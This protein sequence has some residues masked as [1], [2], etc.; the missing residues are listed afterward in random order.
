MRV[1][2]RPRP[3]G[4]RDARA[5]AVLR[6]SWPLP[7]I[8]VRAVLAPMARPLHDALEETLGFIQRALDRIVAGE[9]VEA[10]LHNVR[11]YLVNI[12][13]LVERDPGIEAASDDLYAVAKELARGVDQGTR[14]SGLLREAFLRF[15][16]R[17]AAARPSEQA[18][19]LGLVAT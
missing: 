19:A 2:R 17:L 13:E 8:V 12:L 6:F 16:D 3:K 11:A 9:G 5:R 7:N 15:G 4:G 18:R 14:M 1:D 10:E